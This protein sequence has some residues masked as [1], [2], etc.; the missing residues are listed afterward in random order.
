MARYAHAFEMQVQAYDPHVSV[1]PEYV[2]SVD[3]D[4][5]V[6][7]SDFITLH[8][9][10]TAEN[11]GMLTAEKIEKFKRGCFFINTSRGELTDE[12]ALVEALKDG[13][14][15]AAGVD[16]L[17]GEPEITRNPL[18]QYSRQNSNVIIT[19]HIGGFCPE[20]VNKV[21]RFSCERI[22]E[23]FGAK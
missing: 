21:V 8:V 7:T 20:A 5:L 23:Y 11:R 6:M 15:T 16:V 4:T 17:N 9:N 22:L 10:L 1:F 13:T 2:R 19:P 12:A 14:I 18:W 3:L